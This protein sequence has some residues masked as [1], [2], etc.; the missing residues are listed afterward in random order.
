MLYSFE[1]IF[2]AETN[3]VL[4]ENLEFYDFY[5]K[6]NDLLSALD[7]RVERINNIMYESFTS[8]IYRN[9]ISICN[10]GGYSNLVS[11]GMCRQGI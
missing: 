5:E 9:E 6:K 8:L 4:N 10:P 7:S 2:H 1:C 11:V 3:M